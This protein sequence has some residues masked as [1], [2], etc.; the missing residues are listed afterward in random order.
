MQKKVFS[1]VKKIKLV[2]SCDNE[3]AKSFPMNHN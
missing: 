3:T 2:D 1:I